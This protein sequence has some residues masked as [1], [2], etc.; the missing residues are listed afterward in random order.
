LPNHYLTIMNLPDIPKYIADYFNFV[1][2]FTASPRKALEPYKAKDSIHE[3]L[4][5]FAAIGIFFSW[6][7]GMLLQ[8]L[9]E[10]NHDKSGILKFI[11][12]LDMELL[13]LI[14]LVAVVFCS[15]IF[16]FFL[17]FVLMFE[18]KE[19]KTGKKEYKA[20]SLLNLKNTINGALAFFSVIPVI[21]TLC[22]L[23]TMLGVYNLNH[24]R[25]NIVVILLID[26]P[27]IFIGVASLLW[28]FPQ[29]LSQVQPMGLTR[30]VN[31]SIYS[32]YGFC[33]V[34][35]WLISKFTG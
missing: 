10:S 18:L 2:D 21:L 30:V 26:L 12:R 15:I 33:M 11:A 16:H 6:L 13:P 19:F 3:T 9:G 17:K 29:S 5:S 27:L 14:S 8:K 1:I 31:R 22:F 32:L 20:S 23:L 35:S 34:I 4:I 24:E 28:Y 7:N 25:I